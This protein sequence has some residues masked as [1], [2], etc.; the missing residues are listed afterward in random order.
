M[1]DNSTILAYLEPFYTLQNP[2]DA[3][4]KTD[5]FHDSAYY[6]VATADICL[7]ITYIAIMAVLRDVLRL[8]VFEPFAKWKLTKDLNRRRQRKAA[9]AKATNGSAISH[10]ANGNHLANGKSHSN[11]AANGN[12]LPPPT[13][14]ELRQLN[15]R[16]IRFAEQGWSF[17]Y[18]TAQ[19]AFGLYVHYHL[20]TRLLDP[21]N[22]WLGYPHTPLAAPV[23]VYYLLQTAFYLH[24]VLIL[25][26][27]ARRSDHYQMMTHHVVTVILMLTSYF[28]HFTRVGC[29]IMM[30]MDCSDIFLPLAKMVRYLD[31]SQ[32]ATDCLFGMF[33]VSWLITRHV[34]F[35][36]VIYSTIFH[37]PKLIDFRWDYES[38]VFIT[39]RGH[40]GFGVLLLVL[41]ALQIAWFT[42]IC[43]VAWRVVTGSGAEDERS[44][45]EDEESDKKEE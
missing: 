15:H 41:Q 12:A 16:V 42:M 35:L 11:G 31:I 26:A 21:Q 28:T 3:P 27:E 40:I 18:Y 38:K 13:R 25:N 45:E 10:V 44:D 5:S 2:T 33:M 20:P 24:Q 22:L 19:W 14:K 1:A 34:L 39:Y 30:L 32:F 37:V 17:V 29:V 7:V 4:A 23:K 6:D 8:W 9:L 36:F 43:R